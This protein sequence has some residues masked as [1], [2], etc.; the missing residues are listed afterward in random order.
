MAQRLVDVL[1]GRGVVLHT[2][3]I[4]LGELGDAADE[5][6]YVWKAL[7]AA[8]HGHLVPED[9]VAG[10]TARMHVSRGGQLSP[11]G[12][13]MEQESE[14]KVALDQL[15]RERAYSL[16]EKDGRLDGRSEFYW[17]QALDHHLRER[18][19]A[20]W[21]REGCPHGREEELWLRVVSF[22]AQ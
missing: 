19:Y 4:T 8:A 17:H 13:E 6:Q 16:W 15:I 3:P 21:Q 1:S 2:Y 10:L 18:A 14:T 12:D 9:E 11:Y 5:R 20:L 22:G 7:D